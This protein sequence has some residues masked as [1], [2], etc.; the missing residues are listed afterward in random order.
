MEEAE[1]GM[2][3]RTKKPYLGFFESFVPLG[4]VIFSW[5]TQAGLLEDKDGMLLKQQ[6]PYPPERS[7]RRIIANAHPP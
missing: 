7:R 2:V 3:D 1:E 4:G 6:H 5:G